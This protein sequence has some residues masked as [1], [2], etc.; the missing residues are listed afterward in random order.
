[1]KQGPIIHMYRTD[2]SIPF[3][4][5]PHRAIPFSYAHPDDLKNAQDALRSA[6]SEVIKPD[7]QVENPVTRARGVLRLEEHATPELQV[8]FDQMR[9]MQ[10]E[11]EQLRR[12]TQGAFDTAMRATG[13]V[14][15]DDSAQV[16]LHQLRNALGHDQSSNQR[17]PR[18]QIIVETMADSADGMSTIVAE[19]LALRPKSE[20]TQKQDSNKLIVTIE[21]VGPLV[22]HF[23]N[24]VKRIPGVVAVHSAQA[25]E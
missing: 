19:I 15:F 18:W 23:M 24:R 21:G 13:T 25:I 5:A 20:I 7:F 11:L 4:V 8:L 6:V 14:Q 17:R 16:A 9:S 3:D 1:M 22:K 12:S 10:I 2:E